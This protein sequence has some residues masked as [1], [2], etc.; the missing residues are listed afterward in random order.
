M[1]VT[2]YLYVILGP[3]APAAL[4]MLHQTSALQFRADP[5][6]LL[7]EGSYNA[8]QFYFDREL[9]IENYVTIAWTC[10]CSA[11]LTA[12]QVETLSQLMARMQD[13][14]LHVDEMHEPGFWLWNGAG[15]AT[16][17]VWEV[18]RSSMC[19]SFAISRNAKFKYPWG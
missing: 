13:D 6:T 14:N 11:Q 16:C 8:L 15:P 7:D 19:G 12:Q 3:S 4:D 2:A 9:S 10:K 18:P 5:A 17:I 1:G